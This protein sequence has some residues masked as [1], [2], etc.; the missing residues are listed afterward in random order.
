MLKQCEKLL[1]EEKIRSGIAAAVSRA[2]AKKDIAGRNLLRGLCD[3]QARQLYLLGFC[4]KNSLLFI[5][6]KAHG[7]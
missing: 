4:G 1:R 3:P 2:A 6:G 7:G 5:G